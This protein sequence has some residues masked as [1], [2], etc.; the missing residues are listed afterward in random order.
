MEEK[1]ELNYIQKK[2]ISKKIKKS[3][4]TDEIN[5]VLYMIIT[6]LYL[7]IFGFIFVFILP[8]AL[9]DK[10]P[11][12][13]F[14]NVGLIKKINDMFS[15]NYVFIKT[16]IAVGMLL[17]LTIIYRRCV[18]RRIFEP[19]LDNEIFMNVSTATTFT[20]VNDDSIKVVKDNDSRKRYIEYELRGRRYKSCNLVGNTIDEL[21]RCKNRLLV[22]EFLDTRYEIALTLTDSTLVSKYL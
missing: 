1:I 5:I 15:K 10:I 12:M 2:F 4:D 16:I 6:T 3:A 22:I 11:F 18:H 8:S 21:L 14:L 7:M 17:V 20:L 9:S 13:S 19:S